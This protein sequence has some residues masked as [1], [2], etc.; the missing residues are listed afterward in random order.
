ME[1][2][3]GGEGA[4]R[5]ATHPEAIK[6]LVKIGMASDISEHI[7]M[8]ESANESLIEENARL[9]ADVNELADGLKL[10]SEVGIKMADEVTRLK[11]EVFRLEEIV[12][13]DAIDKKYGMCCDASAQV[14]RLTK[15]GDAMIEEL[16]GRYFGKR[17]INDWNAA[18]EGKGQS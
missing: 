18:K 11:A 3:G 8:V 16:N 5:I 14:E 4:M 10:A 17:L 9:K 6:H 1:E 7:K 13:S 15:A 2:P 12:G